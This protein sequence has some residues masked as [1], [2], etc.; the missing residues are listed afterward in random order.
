MT[1]NNP[2][3]SDNVGIVMASLE[4]AI[5]FF[6]GRGLKRTGRATIEGDW[7][8]LLMLARFATPAV[9]AEHHPGKRAATC[10]SCSP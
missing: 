5:D 8:T 2:K 7:V 3:R 4:E 9:V 1:T 10:A 6:T